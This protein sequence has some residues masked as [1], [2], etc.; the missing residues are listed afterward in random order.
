MGYSEKTSNLSVRRISYQHIYPIPSLRYT[1]YASVR[2]PTL[3][4]TNR[5]RTMLFGDTLGR[6]AQMVEQGIADAQGAFAPAMEPMRGC[7][8]PKITHIRACGVHVCRMERC[9][10]RGLRPVRNP[11]QNVPKPAFPWALP[12]STSATHPSVTHLFQ[13]ELYIFLHT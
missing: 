7:R 1:G 12:S 6:R 2:P 8:V 10:L 9:T 5:A 13:Q 11:T 3:E 4:V